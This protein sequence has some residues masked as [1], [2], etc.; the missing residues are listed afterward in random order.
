MAGPAFLGVLKNPRT[1][2]VS[3]HGNSAT[4][5]CKVIRNADS[6]ARDIRV[7]F[8]ADSV[9]HTFRNVQPGDMIPTQGI[10]RIYQTSTTATIVEIFDM[11]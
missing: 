11:E 7:R 6:V 1:I 3:G 2:T 5:L 10:D 8:Q 9:D 4:D